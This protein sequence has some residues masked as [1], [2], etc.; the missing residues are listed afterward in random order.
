[1]MCRSRYFLWQ[2]RFY[3]MSGILMLGILG[4]SMQRERIFLFA[5]F[6][7]I[8][9]SF[10]AWEFTKVADIVVDWSLAEGGERPPPPPPPPPA[11]AAAAA[12]GHTVLCWWGG[13]SG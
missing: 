1:M 4:R 3:W 12:V 9:L 13:R 6:V 5:M 11:A 2:L 10:V 8:A 7:V